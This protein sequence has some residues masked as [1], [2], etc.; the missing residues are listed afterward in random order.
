MKNINWKVR[1]Q[2]KEFLSS[3]VALL[4]VLANQIAQMFGADITIISQEVT[5]VVETVLMILGL[6]GVVHDPTTKGF[7]DSEQAMTYN[8]PKKDEENF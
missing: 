7:G 5:E 8:S 3:L 6:I 1:F 4:L 2:S